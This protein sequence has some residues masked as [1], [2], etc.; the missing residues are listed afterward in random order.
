M[1]LPTQNTI[2]LRNRDLATGNLHVDSIR[3]MIDAPIRR[4]LGAS[5]DAITLLVEKSEWPAGWMDD[6]EF[7]VQLNNGQASDDLELAGYRLAQKFPV[8]MGNEIDDPDGTPE[9]KQ[10]RLVIENQLRGLRDG[11]GNLINSGTLNELD[12]NGEVDTGAASY[13]TVQQLVDAALSATGLEFE[14]AGPG[15]N[16]NVAGLPIDAPGPLDWGNA[17]PIEELEAL[18]GRIGWVVVQL[19]DGTIA[20]RRLLRAGEEIVIPSGYLDIAE[21]FELA[22]TPSLHSSQIVITSG[23]T[24]ATTI[25]NRTLTDLEWVVYDAETDSWSA[26]S[27]TAINDY[28]GGLLPADVNPDGG[29]QIAQLF[30]AVRLTGTDLVEASKFINIPDSLDHGSLL[31][32]AGSAGVVEALCC[33]KQAGDQLI[34]T[35]EDDADPMIRLDGVRAISGKGVFVL[36]GSVEFVRVNA[37]ESGR[38]SDARVLAGSELRVTFAH[39]SNTGDFNVDYFARGY[40]WVNTMGTITIELMDSTELEDAMDDPSVPKVGAPFL[41]RVQTYD[42]ATDTHSTL[43]D[44]QL[45][46]VAS[47]YASFYLAEATA[48]A[49]V[50]VL[51]GIHDLN[52]GDWNGAISTVTFDLPTLRTIVTVNQHE[53]PRS[54]YDRIQRAAGRSIASGIGQVKLGRSAAAAGDLR[55]TLAAQPAGGA[56]SDSPEQAPL[57]RG[58]ERS[59]SG[60]QGSIE[61][62]PRVRAELQTI[63]ENGMILARITGDSANGTNRFLYDWEEVRLASDEPVTTGAQRTSSTHGKALNLR[64]LLNDASG[65][66]GNGVDLANLPAGFGVQP[67]AT[68][69]AVFLFGPYKISGEDRWLFQATNAIDGECE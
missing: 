1:A 48:Q 12:E 20:V 39:E 65:I 52:P 58:R 17:R 47:Q 49:G 35:P 25:T 16:S 42:K 4:T 51:P 60:Q 6:G 21:P 69:G 67:I 43:N 68:K 45:E 37:I 28:K 66:Q 62:G 61:S 18:L 33:V 50:I 15:I 7:I 34:N 29:K 22:S 64:E 41:R 14:G 44:T 46:A 8:G 31:S 10:L 24:R 40:K 57:T 30:R 56:Q 59:M 53:V 3:A 32:F 13:R 38:R 19:N 27:G 2:R 55:Y 23:A 54:D 63:A 11:L 9:C 26:Q 36:P 5:G